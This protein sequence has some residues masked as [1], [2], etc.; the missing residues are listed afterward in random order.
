[1]KRT[2]VIVCSVILV[3]GAVGGV[4]FVS[5]QIPEVADQMP[6][7]ASPIFVTLTT[8]LNDATIPLNEPTTINLE[9]IG[10][11]SI[12][13]VELW[14]DGTRT[15]VSQ[16][17]KGLT[18]FT[19]TWSWVPAKPGTHTLIARASDAQQRQGQSNIVRVVASHDTNPTAYLG[20]TTQA[21]DTIP[22]IAKKFNVPPQQ[23]VDANPQISPNASIPAG[24]DVSVPVAESS[25]PGPDAE[26][27]ATEPASSN[28]PPPPDTGQDAPPGQPDK[29]V[30]W[31]KGLAKLF[32]QSKIPAKPDLAAGV[33]GCS[34]KLII[35]DHALNE[36]GFYIYRLGQKPSLKPIATLT[37]HNGATPFVYGDADVAQGLYTYYV[38]EFNPSGNALS[39]P[40]QVQVT[41]TNCKKQEDALQL[42][43]PI[44]KT[45][46]PLDK[47]YCYLKIND[48][49]WQRVP[50]APNTFISPNP[51]GIFDV[52][53]YLASLPINSLK[54]QMTLELDCW[55]WK[56]NDLV[57]LGNAKQTV[58]PGP[59]QLVA[60]Q[61]SF[62][63]I[64]PAIDLPTGGIPGTTPS[65]LQFLG[66]S[67]PSIV[68][69]SKFTNT[70]D[71][72]VCSS[73][74]PGVLAVLG[75]E[76]ACQQAATAGNYAVLVWEWSGGCWPGESNCVSSIDGYRVYREDFPGPA[77]VKDV[78]GQDLKTAIFPLPPQ[79]WP[80]GPN[81]PLIV[82][83]KYA[84]LSM[85]CYWVR[86]YK[87]GVG[88]SPDSQKICLPWET[89]NQVKDLHPANILTRGVT[90]EHTEYHVWDGPASICAHGL[91]GPGFGPDQIEVGYF[92]VNYD[93]CEGYYNVVSRG[94]VYFD[95]AGIPGN[96]FVNYARLEYDFVQNADSPVIN[97]TAANE[98]LS[99]ANR[100]MLGK[101]AWMG[102]NLGSQV[103]WI[104]GEAYQN[105][106]PTNLAGVPNPLKVDV[107]GAVK[108]WLQGTRPNYGFV[109][110]TKS[111]GLDHED[112]NRCQTIY[113]N[114]TLKLS[115]QIP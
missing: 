98:H 10:S 89:L 96:A 114:L 56:G 55:G 103:Y 37:A 43:D 58:G 16:S 34:V 72:K 49:D 47:I 93:D 108:E 48:G 61:F 102:K 13:E 73:H 112:D 30:F 42:Q 83:L 75:G 68:P 36:D 64:L 115:Y 99:C 32:N 76:F 78:Q 18:Q 22:V 6:P 67:L 79:P 92:H 9:A 35:A 2:L 39:N 77:L 82:K 63:T 59:I 11:P 71:P 15:F 52:S 62:N 28:P 12:V 110:R 51:P 41:G 23:V 65:P 70:N 19:A 106:E 44:L 69:P 86:A 7:Y 97:G 74:M 113:G 29:S 20:Y 80:P 1:M 31:I 84:A 90:H 50:H 25:V 33:D 38:G 85:N 81:D 27:S 3:L 53:A 8:P 111:E 105:L 17:E 5:T 46:Q 66:G 21:G 104:P 109:F 100:L 94:A 14:V 57:S 95:L 107:S 45:I 101:E 60:N 88:E 91:A 40:V 4:V 54:N 24:Q 26:S 87:E